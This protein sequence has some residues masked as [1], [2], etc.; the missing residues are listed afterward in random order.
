MMPCRAK[1][2]L[3]GM[4]ELDLAGG[5]GGL[6]LLELERAGRQLE[7]RAAEANGAGGHQH[8]LAAALLQARHVVGQRRQPVVTDLASGLVDQERR[9]DL[10]HQPPGVA[11]RAHDARSPI[12]R[13]RPDCAAARI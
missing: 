5:G 8:D 9:A 11:Q 6:V 13:S 12:F 7:M 3:I 2:R 10:D 1:R 4:G